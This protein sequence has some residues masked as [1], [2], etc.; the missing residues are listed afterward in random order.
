[1]SRWLSQVNNFFEQLDDQAET[2]VEENINTQVG[3]EEEHDESANLDS[4]LA[5]R[6]LAISNEDDDLALTPTKE[7]VVEA[8]QVDQPEEELPETVVAT[9][10]NNQQQESTITEVESAEPSPVE[11][12][13]VKELSGQPSAERSVEKEAEST[14]GTGG[15]EK[16][17]KTPEKQVTAPPEVAPK[18]VGKG[19]ESDAK[20]TP[21]T[22]EDKK[23]VPVEKKGTP[24][25]Q[26]KA[27]PTQQKPKSPAQAKAAVK[28]P[29]PAKQSKPKPPA[30]T[31][32]PKQTPTPKSAPV[33]PPKVDPNPT[34]VKEAREAQKEV[35]TL[36]KHMLALNKQLETAEAEV[37]AQRKELEQAGAFMEKDRAKARTER[38]N[39]RKRHA[40]ELSSVQTQHE[41]TLMEQKTRMEKQLA[42]MAHK[43]RDMEQTRM[44][45]G[46]N[47]DKELQGAVD[48]EQSLRQKNAMLED[49][50]ET[51]LAQIETLQTQQVTLGDR[52]ESLSQAADSAMERE[53]EAEERLDQALSVHAHQI[54][55]RQ[56]RESEL[57]RTIAELGA[58]MAAGR[59]MENSRLS[60]LQKA[61]LEASDTAGGE[62]TSQDSGLR[63]RLDMALH[64][65]ETAQAN[66]DLER[67]R[68]EALQRELKDISNERT[69]EATNHRMR[70]N[71]YD[72]QIS[73]LTLQVSRLQQQ[74]SADDGG[75]GNAKG[76]TKDESSE[77]HALRGQIKELSEEILLRRE[78]MGS[79][80]SEIAAMKSRLKTAL[81]RA[82]KAEVALEETLAG[83]SSDSLDRMERASPSS[84]NTMRRRGGGRPNSGTTTISA[85]MK[86][87]GGG[88]KAVDALDTFSVSTGKYLR[89]NPFARAAFISYL[90]MLHLWTFVVIF[91]HAHNF[92][93]MHRDT[94]DMPHG[95]DA[96]MRNQLGVGGK[97]MAAAVTAA[98]AAT[99]DQKQP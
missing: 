26:A 27:T 78:K 58:A 34:L 38:D 53:R 65:L 54:S 14:T 89:A 6:G 49:E 25:K 91:F 60:D 42:D 37:T 56:S 13:P 21:K 31:P 71:K 18:K 36:R 22:K 43:L 1:M 33:P 66:L 17:A 41:T 45:E 50:K 79:Y 97:A 96:L 68:T 16:T 24:A 88:K 99:G 51:F 81:D 48:R 3:G 67:Q 9:D 74:A 69:E 83:Q 87:E 59:N 7:A 94:M 47:W 12:K 20:P 62:N 72:R 23:H 61:K 70:Q 29:P 90:V 75:S 93:D 19:D 40:E 63:V 8:T 86:L 73:E 57:E 95:P 30:P 55:Q 46:G 92:E 35:R 11:E 4:I 32:P 5:S 39:E 44:Q 28:S 15:A 64:D 52:I 98:K 80:S 82:E 77:V 10:T 2:Y 76:S 84:G 85:A